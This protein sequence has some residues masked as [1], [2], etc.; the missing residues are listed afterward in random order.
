MLLIMAAPPAQTL[1]IFNEFQEPQSQNIALYFQE[2]FSFHVTLPNPA[3]EKL[4]I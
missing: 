3:H 1:A 2:L 4:K